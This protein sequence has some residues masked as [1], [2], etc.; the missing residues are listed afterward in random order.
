MDFKV[1]T[2]QFDQEGQKYK[3]QGIT[4]GSLDIIDSHQMETLLKKVHSRIISQL[5]AID[6]TETPIY[7]AGPPI[8]SL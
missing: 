4:D 6:A 2:M 3:F 5:H 8:H 7:V 1:F